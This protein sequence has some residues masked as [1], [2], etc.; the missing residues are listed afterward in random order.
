MRRN[1]SAVVSPLTLW[2]LIVQ[3]GC[4]ARRRSRARNSPPPITSRPQSPKSHDRSAHQ[5]RGP[6]DRGRPSRSRPTAANPGARRITEHG[7]IR[8]SRGCASRNSVRTCQ[9][10]NARANTWLNFG[11][12]DLAR[13]D[14][15]KEKGAQHL[16][17]LPDSV[18][19]LLQAPCEEWRARQDS[20]LR[21]PA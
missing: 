8:E 7:V 18:A 2:L 13:A 6:A 21:P 19:I 17:A 16:S 4:V 15:R 9:W 10:S 12:R 1:P 3:P 5:P 11:A 20:N 14:P